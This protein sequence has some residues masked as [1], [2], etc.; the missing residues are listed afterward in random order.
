M[1]IS[2]LEGKL[3]KLKYLKLNFKSLCTLT[4]SKAFLFAPT[5]SNSK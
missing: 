3:M 1:G 2:E 4:T 5:L